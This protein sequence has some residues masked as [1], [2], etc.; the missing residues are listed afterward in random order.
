MFNIND[1]VVYVGG[2]QY[3]N[4]DA[5]YSFPNGKPRQG[6]VYCVEG[7]EVVRYLNHGDIPS[8]YIV[9]KIAVSLATGRSTP[10]PASYFRLVSEVQAENRLKRTQKKPA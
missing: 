2:S 1:K 8:V 7:Y 9:G 4:S 5:D 3:P 6:E 10:W